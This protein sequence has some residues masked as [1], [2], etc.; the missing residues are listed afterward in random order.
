MKMPFVYDLM[1]A[2]TFWQ[3]RK[4]DRMDGEG[5]SGKSVFGQNINTLA[6]LKMKKKFLPVVNVF[7]SD[8]EKIFIFKFENRTMSGR[9]D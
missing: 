1:R 2:E 8:R 9:T 3:D 5:K 7:V 4:L 6:S